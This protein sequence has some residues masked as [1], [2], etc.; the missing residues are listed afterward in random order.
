MPSKHE[1]QLQRVEVIVVAI[2]VVIAL[3]V[4]AFRHFSAS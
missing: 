1:R 3:L 2:G 4:L